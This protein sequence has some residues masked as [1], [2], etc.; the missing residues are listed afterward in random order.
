MTEEKE[1]KVRILDNLGIDKTKK[2]L[3]E[4][5]NIRFENPKQDNDVYYDLNDNF[6]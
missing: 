1:I 5:F 2:I 4:L 6:C 3:E